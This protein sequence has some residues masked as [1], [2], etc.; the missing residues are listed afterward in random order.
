MINLYKKDDFSITLTSGKKTKKNVLNL[1]DRYLNS[2]Y[3]GDDVKSFK[4]FLTFLEQDLKRNI[5]FTFFTNSDYKINE[6]TKLSKTYGK[7]II[8]VNDD[9][10][11]IYFN[12]FNGP[13]ELVTENIVHAFIHGDF[14]ANESD[15]IKDINEFILRQALFVLCKTLKTELHFSELE[16]FLTDKTYCASMLDE[17]KKIQSEAVDVEV[18]FDKKITK[19]CISFFRNK[20][21]SNIDEYYSNSIC[22]RN[23]LNIINGC[24]STNS[25]FNIK[26]PKEMIFKK[27]FMENKVV[28]INTES[29]LCEKLPGIV[30]KAMYLSYLAEAQVR[31]GRED[32]LIP[33]LLYLD[34]ED[35]INNKTFTEV[36]VMSKQYR[37]ITHVFISGLSVTSKID[38][39][40]KP[41][42]L[43][44]SKNKFFLPAIDLYSLNY[45]NNYRKSLFYTGRKKSFVHYLK[46]R[47]I[48]FNE[49]KQF[50]V[51]TLKDNEFIYIVSFNRTTFPAQKGKLK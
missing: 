14:L 27:L 35:F 23:Y 49:L 41:I 21:F 16:K 7:E 50:E 48:T 13:E 37:L 22:L 5:G 8:C 11:N 46:F 19:Q 38:E 25:I 33:H 51:L 4:L 34:A 3:V 24:E 31:V 20:Y 42:L 32:A 18:L 1:R 40:Y 45:I 43:D 12:P 2:L 29:I 9:L 44:Y 36:F 26:K 47:N 10:S 6:I 30:Q 39:R 28:I 17:L 15:Y